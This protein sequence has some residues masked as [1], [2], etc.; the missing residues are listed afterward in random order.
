[1][2]FAENSTGSLDIFDM[3]TFDTH[4][5]HITNIYRSHYS[6]QVPDH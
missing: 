2:L 3:V 6:L 1:M 4:S 5:H